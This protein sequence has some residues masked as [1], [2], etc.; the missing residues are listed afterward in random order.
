M[1]QYYVT[2]LVSTMSD[3]Y[4]SNGLL[5]CIKVVVDVNGED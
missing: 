5:K 2:L 4:S 1:Y 3:T